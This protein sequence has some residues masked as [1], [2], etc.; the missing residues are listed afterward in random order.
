MIA[1][2]ADWVRDT[3]A[4]QDWLAW[5]QPSIDAAPDL[6]LVI[7]AP[8]LALG[9]LVWS[10]GRARRSAQEAA[11]TM[12]AGASALTGGRI[13][14]NPK[15]AN[16]DQVKALEAQMQALSAAQRAQVAALEA[17]LDA[18]NVVLV[19]S[20]KAAPIGAEARAKR[21]D[22]VIGLV[23][24]NSAGA[25]AL[26]RSVLAGQ[27]LDP[28]ALERSVLAG[29]GLDL[30]ALKT[31]AR[32]DQ[33]RAVEKWRR[34]AA[35][36]RGV[37]EGEA[38]AAYEEASRLDPSDFWTWVELSRLYRRWKGDLASARRAAEAAAANA[39][40]DRDRTVA[41]DA[42]GDVLVLAGDLAGAKRASK[43]I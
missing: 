13:K 27:G 35:L 8:I 20:G 15:P 40:S 24:D 36:A 42:I 22:A 3:A 43:P 14:D 7:P 32:S 25:K 23:A 12:R 18:M 10:V 4:G 28:K 31:E 1:A 39:H 41:D 30:E 38:L 17:K 29:Q 33:Q 5:A 16:V 37:D 11:E 9:L 21:N 34:I 6:A 26:E 2:I 19:A